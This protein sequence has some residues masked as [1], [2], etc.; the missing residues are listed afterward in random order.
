MILVWNM[1]LLGVAIFYLREISLHEFT[2]EELSSFC[3]SREL[4]L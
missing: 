3:A 4:S 2:K 1:I